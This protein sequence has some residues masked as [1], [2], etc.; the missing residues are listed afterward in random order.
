[1]NFTPHLQA[2]ERKRSA[3]ELTKVLLATKD[4]ETILPQH[5]RELLGILLWKVTQA[6]SSTHKTRFQSRDALKFR[7][8]GNLRHDHVYQS[9]KMIDAL[10]AAPERADEILDTAIGCT[11]TVAEHNRLHEFEEEYG[12]GRYR[13][14]GIVVM[15]T[16]HQPPRPLD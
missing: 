2:A 3:V 13:K 6:E 11:V 15:D 1:M 16:S 5:L 12:W 9:A 4:Q 7:N 10:L 14:A 8:K